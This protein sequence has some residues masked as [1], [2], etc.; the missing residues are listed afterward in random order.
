MIIPFTPK[1]G[2][3]F[4]RR[5]C[6]KVDKVDAANNE[7]YLFYKFSLIIFFSEDLIPPIILRNKKKFLQLNYY[8]NYGLKN[9]N[10]QFLLK[11]V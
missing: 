7:R 2:D 9:N 4:D 6:E 5:Y 10:K 11:K 1:K 8:L 3:N